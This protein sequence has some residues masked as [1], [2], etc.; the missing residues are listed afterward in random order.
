MLAAVE[1][2]TYQ[3]YLE[4]RW[5]GAGSQ[6]QPSFLSERTESQLNVAHAS[7]KDEVESP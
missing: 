2:S 7:S 5:K 1:V 6:E 4:A 3:Q